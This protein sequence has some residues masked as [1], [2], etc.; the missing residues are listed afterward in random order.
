M[1]SGT[2]QWFCLGIM[3]TVPGALSGEEIPAR[4]LQDTSWLPWIGCWEGASEVGGDEADAFVVCFEPILGSE[5]VDIRTFTGGALASVEEMVADGV[6]READEGGCT[7]TQT[8]SWSED[9]ARVFLVSELECGEGVTRRT[10][11]VL[12]I[13]PG[14]EGWV[15]IQSVQAGDESPLIGIRTFLPASPTVLSEDGIVS[16]AL[17]RELAVQTARTQAGGTLTPD[18]LVESVEIVGTGVTNALILE[19][20]E[21][22]GL[23]RET[24]R[25]LADRGVPG[26]VL[27]VLVAVSYPDQFAIADGSTRAQ[28]E[29]RSTSSER[30]SRDDWPRR[31]S[32]RGYSPWGMGYDLYWDPFWSSAY[33]FGYGLRGYGYPY[34]R[35]GSWTY[36][37]PR[38]VFV[39]PPVVQAR[40]SLSRDRGVV[41]GDGRV[42]RDRSSNRSGSSSSPPLSRSRGSGSGRAAP[43]SSYGGSRTAPRSSSSGNADS[44]EPR[45]ARPR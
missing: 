34:G 3:L 35:F 12:S 43:S 14:G 44:P 2:L 17:G 40:S 1:H 23:D 25:A 42:A 6:A 29:I 38:L 7:G 15:E 33:R 10:R 4:L 32:Y 45:R 21:A 9:R 16:P 18:G 8:A 36:G 20:G 39:E 27:D 5:G 22:F 30:S 13:L 24:L 19:R 31:Q 11:G 26:E 41:G 37:S 28:P